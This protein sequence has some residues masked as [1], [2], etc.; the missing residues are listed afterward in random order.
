MSELKGDTTRLIT[1]LKEQC[2]YLC[3]SRPTAVN[4]DKECKQMIV[5]AEELTRDS[6]VSFESM[7]KSLTEYAINLLEIDIKV[8]KSIGDFGAEYINRLTNNSTKN[9]L[10]HCNTGS[11]ATGL[12][13]YGI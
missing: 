13:S 6:N 9:I 8:N 3:T 12:S 4:I 11:L 1:R 5:F 7:V 2:K 10:T